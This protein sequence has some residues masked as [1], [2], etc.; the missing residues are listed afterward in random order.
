MSFIESLKKAI[1]E[2]PNTYLLIKESKDGIITYINPEL[3]KFAQA[4]KDQ[5]ISFLQGVIKSLQKGSKK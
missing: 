2:K 3:D 1:P 5:T 4:Y